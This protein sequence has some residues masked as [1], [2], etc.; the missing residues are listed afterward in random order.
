MNT[1]IAQHLNIAESTILKIEEWAN[2]FF[3]V[4]RK[5]GARFVSKKVVTMK[6]REEAAS[7]IA[8]KIN[9]EVEDTR[10]KVWSKGDSVRIYVTYEGEQI[11]YAEIDESGYIC[12]PSLRESKMHPQDAKALRSIVAFSKVA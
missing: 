7:E 8:A 12:T 6:T 10:A 5:I 11:G 1:Q 9:T 2:V 4:C 3:V